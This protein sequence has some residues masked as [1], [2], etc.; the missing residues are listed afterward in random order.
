MTEETASKGTKKA[1]VKKT[2][3]KTGAKTG[4]RQSA[5]AK[6]PATKKTA[7]TATQKTPTAKPASAKK[8]AA[9]AKGA[10]AA[11]KKETS[12]PKAKAPTSGSEK[13]DAN[14]EAKT[15][16]SMPNAEDFVSDLKNRNWPETMKRA[17]FTIIFGVV[18]YFVLWAS[19]FI[20]F[21]QF[22]VSLLMGAPNKNIT[23]VM[24]TA[25]QYLAE[26]LAYLS[27]K[28]NELPFPFGNDFPESDD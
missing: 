21:L 16:T 7:P 6:T 13:A 28:T 26:I 3:A 10:P 23:S 11:V 17:L 14:T 25:S 20:A 15:E 18:G 19:F 4:A 8:P 5:A 2:A 9:A 22:V 1:P 24:L 27:F 12:R